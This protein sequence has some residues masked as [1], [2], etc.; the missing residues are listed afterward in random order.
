MLKANQRQD[1][2]MKIK[3]SLDKMD[4]IKQYCEN[5]G[6]ELPGRFYV[7]KY[8]SDCYGNLTNEK[9]SKIT[10]FNDKVGI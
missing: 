1:K 6:H 9:N 8:C 5:C 4:E 10:L 2:S 7:Y 3:E